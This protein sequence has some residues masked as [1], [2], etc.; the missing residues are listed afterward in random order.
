MEFTVPAPRPPGAELAYPDYALMLAG[1]KG[2]VEKFNWYLPNGLDSGWFAYDKRSWTPGRPS[3][4][5]HLVTSKGCVARCTFCERPTVGYRNYDLDRLDAHLG[6][7]K[8]DFNVG[9]INIFEENFGSNKKHSYEVARLFK[10]HDM[11]WV[12]GGTRVTNVSYEDLK[13]YQDHQ[14]SGL[15]FGVE[16]GSQTI[17]D[18]MEK[19]FTVQQV[20]SALENCGKLRLMAPLSVMAGMPGETLDTAR[21][22]GRFIGDIAYSFGTPPHLIGG[23]GAFYALPMPGTPL[24]EYGQQTGLIPTDVD[25]EE[26]YFKSLAYAGSDKVHYLNLSGAPVREVL[27]WDILMALEANRTFYRKMAQAPRPPLGIYEVAAAPAAAVAEEP[28]LGAMSRV[29]W[30]RME[31][32][33]NRL[34]RET[35]TTLLAKLATGMYVERFIMRKVVLSPFVASLPA[36]P[37]DAVLKYA[38]Y[39]EYLLGVSVLRLFGLRANKAVFDRPRRAPERLEGDAALTKQ[40]RTHSLRTVVHRQRTAPRSKS[41]L[42]SRLLYS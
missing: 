42:Q 19:K 7:L 11:I 3:R 6:M 14:C 4:M 18:V 39:A 28:R 38:I 8:R 32:L 21:E 29:L 23:V 17:L 1:A 34:G 13:F 41:A 22:S 25:G 15:K 40:G 33:R 35:A 26:A 10:K 9:F 5:A 2:D 27:F 30:R 24:Y 36:A 12:A 16:S 37:V 20:R 31:R